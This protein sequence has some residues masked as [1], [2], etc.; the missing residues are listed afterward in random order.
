V[1]LVVSLLSP[2]QAAPA[3][4]THGKISQGPDKT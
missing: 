2:A 4:Q 1:A 3:E